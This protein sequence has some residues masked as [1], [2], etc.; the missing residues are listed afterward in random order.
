MD[1]AGSFSQKNQVPGLI[2]RTGQ[3]A[4][5]CSRE[6]VFGVVTHRKWYPK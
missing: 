4:G 6:N 5:E 2:F 3:G 1:S